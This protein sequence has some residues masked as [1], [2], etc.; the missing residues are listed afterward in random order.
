[1]ITFN[2]DE[3]LK[4]YRT[5]KRAVWIK[6]ILSNGKQRFHDHF[7]GWVEIKKECEK[8]NLSIKKMELQ[9]RSH[10][11]EIP[12]D[13]NYDGVYLIRSVMGT[14]GADCKQYYTSGI[15]KNGRVTKKMWLIP[16][17]IVEKELDD[18]ISECFEEAIIYSPR[19]AIHNAKKKKK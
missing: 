13:P 4:H 17:L 6:C 7:S 12:I 14:M 8:D 19:W 1:M 18:D 5:N 2:K 10:V 11:E 16:E 3:W 9:F 15:L